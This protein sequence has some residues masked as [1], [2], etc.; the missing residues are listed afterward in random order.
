MYNTLYTN[1]KGEILENSDLSL[2]GQSGGDWVA[3]EDEEMIPLPKGASL[4][5]VPYHI[6]VG[7]DSHD[8]PVCQ[9]TKK[10]QG[11]AVAALLPQGFTRTLL[12]ACVRVDNKENGLPLFAYTAV[13]LKNGKIY[14]AAVQSDEHRKWHP[15]NYNTDG[16]PAKISRM[17]KKFPENRIVR[18]LA[19]CSLEYSCYTAQT[20]FYQRWEGGIPTMKACNAAC[21]ACISESRHGVDSPQNRL[22]FHPSVEEIVELGSEHLMKARDGIISFGQ[23]CEGEPSLNATDL[24]AAIAGIR[25]KTDQGTVNINSNA[26][27]TKGIS[28]MCKAGLDSIRVTLFSCSV[29]NYRRYHCPKDYSLSDVE[30]SIAC[31]K[32]HGLKVS[33]N[34]LT[35]P[36][37]TDREDEIDYLLNFIEKNRIDMIQLRNLNMDPELL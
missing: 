18:Q 33:L 5:R 14:A 6:P 10:E 20:I 17:L 7:L 25:G 27:Y 26:G 15:C 32:D 19:R 8:R 16:L 13:G 37:F 35:F 9:D 31:A 12:P 21:L 4:V 3:P 23:G 2:L 11:W 1:E 30:N 34:L 24:S 29:E 22:T 28:L 36:G